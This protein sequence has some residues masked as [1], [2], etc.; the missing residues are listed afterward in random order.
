M[1]LP[2]PLVNGWVEEKRNPSDS[3]RCRAEEGSGLE[4]LDGEQEGSGLEG[5]D[6][7]QECSV[8]TGLLGD[9]LEDA[10]GLRG[11]DLEAELLDEKRDKTDIPAEANRAVV[12]REGQPDFSTFCRL[13]S[14]SS[15]PPIEAFAL[16]ST[17]IKDSS[18]CGTGLCLLLLHFCFCVLP[19]TCRTHCDLHGCTQFKSTLH[20]SWHNI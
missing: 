7:E 20:R 5:L 6:G 13:A 9:G 14:L 8:E 2:S 17:W 15:S 10:G 4:G 16:D 3:T 12:S 18:D 1:Q 19:Q 11:D